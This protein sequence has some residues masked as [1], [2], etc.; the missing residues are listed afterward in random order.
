MV[1]RR[2]FG[3]ATVPVHSERLWPAAQA[4]ALVRAVW[5]IAAGIHVHRAATVLERLGLARAEIGIKLFYI[6]GLHERGGVVG[7]AGG[8]RAGA[9]W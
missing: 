6:G 8:V 5:Q 1:Q 3:G 2:L 9:S 4:I 7:L